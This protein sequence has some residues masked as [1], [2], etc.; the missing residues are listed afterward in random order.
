M[1]IGLLPDIRAGQEP[2]LGLF[3]RELAA[4]GRIEG[5][6][7]VYL[8]SGGFYAG[9]VLAAVD[10]VLN[11]QPDVLLIMNLGY[12]EAARRRTRSLPMV[13]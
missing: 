2:L 1:R 8:R 11:Q 13:L 12:A 5:R 7:F 6:D 4:L 10:R 9:D 3:N